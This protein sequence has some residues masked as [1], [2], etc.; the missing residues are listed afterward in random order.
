MRYLVISDIH[1]NLEALDATLAAAADH[2]R[3]LVLGDLVG[4]GADPNP[5]IE[6]IRA[7]PSVTIVRGNHDKVGAGLEDV[8]GFNYLARH[9]IAWTAAALT[10]DNKAWLAAL[11]QG[12]ALVEA[13]VEICH[14]APF[15]EDC[16]IF[17]DLDAT[18]AL[19]TARAPLC[20]FGHTHVPAVYRFEGRSA[21]GP[22][23]EGV[24]QMTGPP[25]GPRFRLALEPN[26]HYLVNCGSV[27]QPRDGDP[28]AAFGIVDT[29][30]NTLTITRVPYDVATAQAK[31]IAAGLPEVL[32]QRL[33]V[34]R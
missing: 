6:R 2:D 33:A 28:H 19:R 27:G 13:R 31:I 8:E 16:Y 15:D 20:L 24:L 17:D 12:P 9:A 11:P 26:A 14:G 25:R 29:S 34:G 22:R 18:R 7:L 1:A 4:Y 30:D 23:G 10:P 5:V 32:A 3:V 21:E